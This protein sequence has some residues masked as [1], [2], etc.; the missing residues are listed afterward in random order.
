MVQKGFDGVDKRFDRIDQRLE[1]I[2]KFLL[3]DHRRRIIM[4]EEKVKRLEDLLVVK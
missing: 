2:E 3:E 4:L 1:K